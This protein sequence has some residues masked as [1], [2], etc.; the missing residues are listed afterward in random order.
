MSRG[1]NLSRPSREPAR[2]ADPGDA[3]GRRTVV[4]DEA[5]SGWGERVVSDVAD[6]H[7]GPAVNPDHASA[8]ESFGSRLEESQMFHSGEGQVHRTLKALVRSLEE[9]GID[10]VIVGG[11]ALNAHGYARETV[12]VDVLVTP[13]G[14]ES[15]RT[16]CVGKG[17][18]PGFE[19]ARKSFRH[20]DTN[21]KVEFLTTGEYPGDGKPKP[22]AFPDPSSVAITLDRVRVISLS[23]L[24]ELKLASGMT[25]RARL[26]DLADVQDLIRTLGLD[27]SF[28]DKLDPYVRDTFLDLLEAVRKD[29]QA[30][31]P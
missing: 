30:G 14:L 16:Q 11:M 20:T 25:N 31:E 9:A 8:L 13:E 10:Y 23:K 15:F 1:R 5:A 2:P 24:V 12:D 26:R 19:G 3:P 21:V 17:Y 29:Q 6:Q 4:G 28:A 27:E 18:R 7:T 22:V